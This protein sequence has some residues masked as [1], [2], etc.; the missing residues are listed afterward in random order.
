M[1][2]RSLDLN[3]LLGAAKPFGFLV[4][5]GLFFQKMKLDFLRQSESIYFAT[6][7]SVFIIVTRPYTLVKLQFQQA[8]I[9]L[10]NIH[11]SFNKYR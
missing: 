10:I 4:G 7:K 3:F 8:R 11:Q 2:E 5:E 6:I 9:Y 1:E